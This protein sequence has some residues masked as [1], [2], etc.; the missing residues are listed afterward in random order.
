MIGGV[1]DLPSSSFVGSS[2]IG[3]GNG[4]GSNMIGNNSIGHIH[5]VLIFIT[6]FTCVRSSARALKNHRFCFD[7]LRKS[8]TFS[9][10]AKIGMKISV[11]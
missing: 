9:I 1:F 8:F 3:D 2:T 4:Q 11:S 10:A 5:L 6:D 7:F